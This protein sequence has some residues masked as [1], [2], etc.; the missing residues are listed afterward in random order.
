MAPNELIA[1]DHDYTDWNDGL[2]VVEPLTDAAT[3]IDEG[4]WV[5]GGINIAATGLDALNALAD[6]F[7][8][9]LTSAF[10][11]FIDHV[12]PL[13]EMLDCLAGNPDVIQTNAGTWGNVAEALSKAAENMKAR[14]EADTA[15]WEG[16]AVDAYKPVAHA[17]VHMISAASTAAK[18]VGSALTGAGTAVAVVRYTVRDLIAM[19]MSELVQYLVRS[20]ALAGLSLGTATPLLIA[21]GLRVVSKWATKVQEWLQKIVQSITRLS[22]IVSE[23]GPVMKKVVDELTLS[24]PKNTAVYSAQADDKPYATRNDPSS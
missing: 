10:S 23:L 9:L 24:V 3:R 7:G 17:Q 18:A 20:S 1:D 11:W 15:G 21:D 13:H 12:S 14:V 2:A 6:P 16:P 22:K 5:E 4:D 8:T 19:G